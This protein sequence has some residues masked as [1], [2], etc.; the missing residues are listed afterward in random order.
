[1]RRRCVLGLLSRRRHVT[2]PQF[3]LVERS[4]PKRKI[5]AARKSGL[6]SIKFY[7][8]FGERPGFQSGFRSL[9]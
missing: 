9:W 1:M 8:K 6:G 5:N 4:E 3:S 2:G 7:E